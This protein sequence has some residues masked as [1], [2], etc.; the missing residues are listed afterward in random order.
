MEVYF[1]VCVEKE[2]RACLELQGPALSDAVVGDGAGDHHHQN[3]GDE[4]D[5]L[6]V[7]VRVGVRVGVCM[8]GEGGGIGWMGCV[9]R[10]DSVCRG[11]LVQ[12]GWHGSK[13]GRAP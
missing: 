11:W 8:L 7:G 6:F 2:N 5:H 12:I 13:Q 4:D 3:G 1:A 10:R 9:R